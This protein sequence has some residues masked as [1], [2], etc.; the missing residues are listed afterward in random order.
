MAKG[1]KVTISGESTFFFLDCGMGYV[2]IPSPLHLTLQLNHTVH[3]KWVD[4][5]HANWSSIHTRKIYE[6]NIVWGID[7]CVK[8]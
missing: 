5:Y 8:R 2:T 7:K 1:H 3:L 6:D 4:L